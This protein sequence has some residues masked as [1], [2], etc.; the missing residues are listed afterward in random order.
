MEDSDVENPK[1]AGMDVSAPPKRILVAMDNDIKK[2]NG[3]AFRLALKSMD[4]RRDQ[5]CV[6]SFEN[7]LSLFVPHTHSL[8][9]RLLLLF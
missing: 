1:N 2:A 7:S 6:L 5:L 3:A 8:Q 9:S 4:K